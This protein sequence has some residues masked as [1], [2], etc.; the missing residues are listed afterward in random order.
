MAGVSAVS[1]HLRSTSNH[2]AAETRAG[3]ATGIA[4]NKY[5]RRA[6]LMNKSARITITMRAL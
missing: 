6:K 5:L 1:L 4:T 3:M 2:V